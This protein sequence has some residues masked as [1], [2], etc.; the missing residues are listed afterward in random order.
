MSNLDLKTNHVQNIVKNLPPEPGVYLFKDKKHRVLYV[1]KAKNLRTRIRSYF[2]QGAA[3]E[4]RKQKMIFETV[5]CDYLVTGSELEAFILEANLIKEHKSPY[6]IIL[7][8]DKHYPYLCLTMKDKW[9]ALKVLRSIKRDGSIYF[10]PYVPSGNMWE[11]LAFIRRTFPIRTCKH[12]LNK[13]MRPC[14]KY[15]MGRCA[16]PCA[17]KIDRAEYMKIVNDVKL[18]L[19]G[20]NRELLDQL[21]Q[22]MLTASEDLDFEK[23]IELRDRVAR[24]EKALESQ[25]IIS[26][27]LGNIDVF[28]LY[29]E[30]SALSIQALFIRSGMLTGGRDFFLKGSQDGTDAEVLAAAID[31][32]YA[33]DFPPPKE[34]LLPMEHPEGELL[35]KWLSERG[36]K[37]VHV[38][39]APKSGKRAEL[40]RMA[41]ENALISFKRNS[42]KK[43]DTA[44]IQ[45]KE[46]LGLKQTPEWIHAFDV[47]TL[48]GTESVGSR[49]SWKDG[50]FLK[51]EYR[52]YRIKTVEGMDDFAMMQE[53]I[54]R[55]YSNGNSTPHL[56]II[57]GGRGQLESALKVFGK[58]KDKI[59]IIGLAKMRKNID[60]PE[61]VFIPGQKHAIKLDTTNP[62]THIL[63]RIRDESHRFAINYHRQLR[64]ARS[65]SSPLDS[66]HGVGKARR[67]TLLKA[68][69]SIE[70]IRAASEEEL[71]KIP[72]INS[73]IAADIAAGLKD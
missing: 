6:N 48:S 32:F 55:S 10:G 4:P 71:V 42:S 41:Q 17:D 51:D 19:R 14:M 40:V 25:R 34:I 27:G 24:I 39:A 62:A 68:F 47:S 52:R 26:P 31:Q 21:R 16:G 33:K 37:S 58:G 64:A 49:V 70:A 5:T 3:L 50:H 7:R 65:L 36:N 54:S 53:I 11:T 61:R 60:L 38:K 43:A 1:G 66:I 15:Q 67:L 63:Q 2:R 22:R 29:R 8:D 9:P 20:H 72:G 23:A 69:G 12:R 57:D 59:E 44:L 56:I 35:A 28:A 18:F 13:P 30:E 45:L 46:I 73:K